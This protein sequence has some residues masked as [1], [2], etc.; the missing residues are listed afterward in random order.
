M[1]GTG[2]S[3]HGL[4]QL[5]HVGSEVMAHGLG[6]PQA[7]WNLPGPGIKPMATALAICSDVFII[8]FLLFTLYLIFYSFPSFLKWKLR[9]LIIDL[10]SSLMYAFNTINLPLSTAFTASTKFDKLY[11]HFHLVENIVKFSLEKI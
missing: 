8:Y 5:Q 6:C 10:S 7:M 11:F 4:Q 2:S 9:L 3:M 1:Q